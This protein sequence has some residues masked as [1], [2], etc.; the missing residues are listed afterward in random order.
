MIDGNRDP[1]AD[2]YNALVALSEGRVS[3]SEIKRRSRLKASE[4][5]LIALTA[6]AVAGD[7]PVFE[8]RVRSALAEGVTRVEIRELLLELADLGVRV[9]DRAFGTIPD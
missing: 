5:S 1:L 9:P 4:R 2:P 7:V 8:E 3:A 6:A